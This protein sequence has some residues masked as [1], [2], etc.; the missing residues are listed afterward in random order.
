MNKSDQVESIIRMEETTKI[1]WTWRRI[2]LPDDRLLIIPGYTFNPWIGCVKVAKECQFCYAEGL[3][4]RWGWKVWGPA[5]NTPRRITSP[6]N[7]KKPL[8][9]NKEAEA[10]GHRRSVFCASLADVFEEHPDVAEARLQLWT[11]IEQTPWLNWLLLT[12]RPENILRIAPWG[13][14]SW[15]DNVWT[16][17]SAGTQEKAQENVSYLLDVPSIVR[18][19][20]C[21]PQLEYVSFAPWLP[22]LQWIICGGESGAKARPF[23]LDWARALRDECQEF[24]VSFFFKQVG[25][26]HH[27]SGGRDLD[28]RTWDELPPEVPA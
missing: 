17:T 20:S 25:G 21:E 26:F 28:G 4:L 8:K 7:W 15:P 16:G 18:F 1:Q 6:A 11:L 24:H 14:G 10:Q 13:R 2:P 9:W 12:K 19:V 27:N 5:A 23:H 22:H 3:A